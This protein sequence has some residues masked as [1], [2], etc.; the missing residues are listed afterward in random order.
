MSAT[1]FKQRQVGR[2]SLE[3]TELGLGGATLAGIFTEVPDE[4]ARATVGAAH[5]AG[6]R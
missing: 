5:H 3:L 6:I 2:T 1:S 4:Q